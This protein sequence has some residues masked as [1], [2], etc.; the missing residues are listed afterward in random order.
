MT[1]KDLII[2]LLK[3]PMNTN[4]IISKEL[5]YNVWVTSEPIISETDTNCIALTFDFPTEKFEIRRK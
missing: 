5:D 3:Y 1:I 2:K 4:I